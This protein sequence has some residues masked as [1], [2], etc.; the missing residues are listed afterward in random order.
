MRIDPTN[1]N[2]PPP[3]AASPESGSKVSANKAG[4]R[5][6]EPTAEVGGFSPTPDLANLLAQVRATPDVRADLVQD[7]QDRAA[8]GELTSRTAAVDTAAALLDGK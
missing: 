3:V 1:V 4:V 8:I 7:V 5:E 2:T 6:S